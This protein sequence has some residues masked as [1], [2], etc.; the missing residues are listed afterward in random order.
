VSSAVQSRRVRIIEN[1]FL[2]A[3]MVNEMVRDLRY[4]VAKIAY[5]LPSVLKEI[6]KDNFD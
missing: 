5:R 1:N 6:D 4:C 2:I 3:E